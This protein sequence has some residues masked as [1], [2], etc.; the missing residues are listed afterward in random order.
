LQL[1]AIKWIQLLVLFKM[2]GRYEEKA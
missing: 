2:T 1:A